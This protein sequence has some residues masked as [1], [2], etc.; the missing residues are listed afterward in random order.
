MKQRQ[1]TTQDESQLL[2]NELFEVQSKLR[3]AGR[4][5][6]DH[7][8][9][10]LSASG[11]RLDLLRSDYPETASSL[12]PVMV[13]LGEAMDRVR[14]MSRELNPPPAAH[15]GLKKALSNLVEAQQESFAG[16]IRFSYL[17]TANLSHD[18]RSHESLSPDT[19]AAIHESAK[20]VL[21]RA[22]S[23]PSASR[24]AVVV[25]GSRNLRV[26]IESNGVHWPH[27]DMA[28][29]NRRARPAG[30]SLAATQKTSKLPSRKGTI[31]VILY[32]VR[33]PPGG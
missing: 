31:V 12:E 10:L 28:A 5:L 30:I 18:S 24:I 15:L 4:A 29:L 7:V 16:K 1:P 27:A 8:G 21:A 2:A 6:H 25:R 11:I 9:A 20:A 26:A 23:D 14:A 33:R 3:A 32:A 13:A 19:I 17:A 22:V